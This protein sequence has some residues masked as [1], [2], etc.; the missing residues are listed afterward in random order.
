VESSDVVALV[1]VIVTGLGSPMVALATVRWQARQ[2]SREA[3]GADRRRVLDDAGSAL[4]RFMR[5]NGRFVASWRHGAGD[6]AELQALLE[7]RS[8]AQDNFLSAYAGIG[9]RFGTASEVYRSC[10]HVNDSI[11]DFNSLVQPFFKHQAPSG[12]DK[13]F[14]RAFESLE[15]ARADFLEAGFRVLAARTVKERRAV[16]GS[17]PGI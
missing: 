5:A 13:D 14:D 6:D 10:R 15:R 8:Q 2:S 12:E 16:E 1:S 7:V 11:T 3:S 9:M 4:A 17:A